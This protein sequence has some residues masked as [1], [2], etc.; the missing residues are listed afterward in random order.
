MVSARLVHLV[1]QLRLNPFF[2][3]GLFLA[4]FVGVIVLVALLWPR[5][6]FVP[7]VLE[8][9]TPS[10][11][12]VTQLPS[13][14]EW[15]EVDGE[16]VPSGLPVTYEVQPGDSSWKIAQAFYGSGYNYVDI[17]AANDLP[18]NS[19]LEIGQI[20]EIPE[21]AVK[22]IGRA[23]PQLTPAISTQVPSD[24]DGY[25]VQ[26]GDSLWK[27]AQ[28]ELGDPYRWVEI[29][30]LNRESIGQNPGLI[31]TDTTLQL[32]DRK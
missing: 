5:N 16:L 3:F 10:P 24:E 25:T 19:H 14:I 28:S 20:L 31:Y 8:E 21:T 17:E 1:K 23:K 4:L 12:I 29:Y 22:T 6:T 26:R 11:E 30:Q 9:P 2:G 32:P 7:P 13:S 15:T 18:H 27:I